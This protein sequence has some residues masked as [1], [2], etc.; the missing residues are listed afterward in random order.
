MKPRHATLCHGAT[1]TGAANVVT[2]SC[3]GLQRGPEPLYRQ[4]AAALRTR[5]ASGEFRPGQPLPSLKALQ[6][7]Y[8]VADGTA[9]KAVGELRDAGLVVTTPGLGTFVR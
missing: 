3:V 7:E 5:I 6:D 9:R 2:L 4:L 8:D 1:W